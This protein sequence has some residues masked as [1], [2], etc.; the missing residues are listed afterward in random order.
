MASFTQEL[1]Q[2]TLPSLCGK[3]SQMFRDYT[4]YSINILLLQ[5]QALHEN[6]W[7]LQKTFGHT[8]M[9]FLIDNP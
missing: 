5:K 1:L 8:C 4:N 6:E 9:K 2:W 3:T 7:Y